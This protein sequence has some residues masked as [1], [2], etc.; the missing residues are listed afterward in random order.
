[1]SSSVSKTA[2]SIAVST[3]GHI[4]WLVDIGLLLPL[5]PV[6]YHDSL[7]KTLYLLRCYYKNFHALQMKFFT[8]PSQIKGF[9]EYIIVL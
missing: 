1:V 8:Y 7:V 6:Y 9:C 3:G 2:R 5:P 4:Y